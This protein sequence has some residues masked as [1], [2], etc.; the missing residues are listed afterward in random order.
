MDK[1]SMQV[2]VLPKYAGLLPGA[3]EACMYMQDQLGL[4]LGSTTGFT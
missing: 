3:G 1:G 4:K 2:A